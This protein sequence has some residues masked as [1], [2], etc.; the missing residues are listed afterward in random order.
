MLMILSNVGTL[1][2]VGVL[3]W[4]HADGRDQEGADRGSDETSRR[5]PGGIWQCGFPV[6]G[7]LFIYAEVFILGT[8]IITMDVSSDL[9]VLI[10]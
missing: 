9:C 7:S 2:Y 8:L 3:E 10:E 6:A 4:P 5:L 1:L